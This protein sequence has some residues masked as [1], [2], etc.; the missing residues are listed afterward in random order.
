MILSSSSSPRKQT[1]IKRLLQRPRR[2]CCCF[3]PLAFYSSSS[4][5][6]RKSSMSSALDFLSAT[7][8]SSLGLL[9]KHQTERKNNHPRR[10]LQELLVRW[11]F[12]SRSRVLRRRHRR[13]HHQSSHLRRRWAFLLLPS[14]SSRLTS[15]LNPR[16]SKRVLVSRSLISLPISVSLSRN[17]WRLRGGFCRI[18]LASSGRRL[19]TLEEEDGP[20]SM[21]RSPC[22][23]LLE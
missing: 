4:S 21:K 9:S 22:L 16:D 17:R 14:S 15:F 12:L 1:T 18:S 10:N 8:S 7:L 23:C 6:L 13:L 20:S 3:R 5:F 19:L 11:P 2:S